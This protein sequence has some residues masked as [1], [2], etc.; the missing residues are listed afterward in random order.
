MN[1]F[2]RFMKSWFKVVL[3]PDEKT[4]IIPFG[5]TVTSICLNFSP[6]CPTCGCDKRMKCKKCS[7]N[8]CMKCER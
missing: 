8:E 5:K 6:K 3:S 4:P 1:I 7:K 2:A